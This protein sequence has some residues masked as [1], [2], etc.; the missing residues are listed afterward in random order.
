MTQ[1]P[2]K[3][4]T[5]VYHPKSE[6]EDGSFD[7]WPLVEGEVPSSHLVQLVEKSHADAL[8]QRV[9]ELAGQV[10]SL[11]YEREALIQSDMSNYYKDEN[12]E[13][14]RKLAKCKEKLWKEF[15]SNHVGFTDNH[16]QAADDD[17]KAFEA[18]LNG[19]K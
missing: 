18:E 5:F 6:C 16:Y 17:M 19:D 2:T 3:P 13:L 10:E 4:R 11:Q 7:C 9:K 1:E 12:A 8:E 15:K 14:S